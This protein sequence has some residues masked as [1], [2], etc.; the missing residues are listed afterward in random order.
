MSLHQSVYP[1]TG[2]WVD[3]ARAALGEQ[4]VARLEV[5]VDQPGPMDV[6][7]RLNQSRGQYPCF[8]HRQRALIPDAFSKGGPWYEERGEPG[9]VG[10]R[11]SVD[12][13]AVKAPLTRRADST[14]RRKRVRKSGSWTSSGRMTL[15]AN[16]LP[17]TD[18]AR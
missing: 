1:M 7:Q 3:D 4:D 12:D 16:C 11:V 8:G 2:G 15:T 18:R 6:A 14:S 13:G 17:D 9:N 10:L 5:P